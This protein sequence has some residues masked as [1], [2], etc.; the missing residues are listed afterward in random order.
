[1]RSLILTLSALLVPVA[2]LA[3]GSSTP[4]NTGGAGGSGSSSSGT[5]GSVSSSSSGSG[6]SASTSSSTTSSSTSASSGGGGGT[7]GAPSCN[8]QCISKHP[9]EFKKFA[10]YQLAECG[11][12]ASAPC[13]GMCTATDCAATDPTQVSSACTAC[14]TAEAGKGFGSS[15]TVTAATVDC[16]GDAMCKAFSDCGTCCAISG[17]NCN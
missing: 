17:M 16:A 4:G 1:M 14:L 9:A 5:G 3:C 7:G 6:G 12:K 13:M 10:G 15:C 8:D 2:L 11:C